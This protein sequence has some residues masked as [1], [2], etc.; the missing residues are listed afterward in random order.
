MNLIPR[1][2]FVLIAP[3]K[4]SDRTKGGIMLPE[5]AKEKPNRGTILAVGFSVNQSSIDF[6]QLKV[7]QEVIYSQYAGVTIKEDEEEILIVK[8]ADVI[9]I[10]GGG[11]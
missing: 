4:H 9:A 11:E 8:E 2:D 1:N 7:G 3:T 6:L 5:I 10:I